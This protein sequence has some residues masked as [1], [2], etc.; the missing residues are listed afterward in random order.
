MGNILDYIKWRGDLSFD[1]SEFNEVDNLV[2]SQISYV[3]FDKIAFL[4]ISSKV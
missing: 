1:K 4:L 3:N 2:L